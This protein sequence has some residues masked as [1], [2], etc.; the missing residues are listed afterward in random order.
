MVDVV[1]EGWGQGH[2]RASALGAA[3]MMAMLAAAANGQTRGAQAA[4]GAGRCA[5]RA[6][7]ESSAIALRALADARA[8]PHR[9]RRRRGDHQRP[10]IQPPRGNRDDWRASRCSMRAHAR[11]WTGSPARRGRRRFPTTIARSTTLRGCAR[12]ACAKTRRDRGACGPSAAV[13]VVR[14]RVPDRSRPIRAGTR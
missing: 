1:A 12:Q 6:P 4:P 13:Q 9:A 11:R 2:A 8:E 14:R 10:V 7:A 3:G 5:A